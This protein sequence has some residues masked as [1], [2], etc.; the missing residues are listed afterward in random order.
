[1]T[2]I[3]MNIPEITC[4]SDEMFFQA[5]M[6]SFCT[7]SSHIIEMKLL[8]SPCVNEMFLKE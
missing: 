6:D 1:M 7:R 5:R 4:I 3:L 8:I 2:D